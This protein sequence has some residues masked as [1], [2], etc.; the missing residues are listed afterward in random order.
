MFSMIAGAALTRLTIDKINHLIITIPTYKE[1]MEIVKY[2]D[3]SLLSIDD[4]IDKSLY[5][6]EKL[7]EY[8]QSLI[9]E[10]VTGKIDVREWEPK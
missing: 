8:R 9:S 5:E 2:L 6:I 1:Q 10:A 4:I 3:K 7:K